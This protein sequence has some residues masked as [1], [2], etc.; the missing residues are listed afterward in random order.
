M[1]RA[2]QEGCGDKCLSRNSCTSKGQGV[3][4]R[5]SWGGL[6]YISERS[7]V[8]A[9]I[10]GWRRIKVVRSLRGLLK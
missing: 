6:V 8:V 9:W 3:G 7:V 4:R 1:Y 10:G 2:L 5:P